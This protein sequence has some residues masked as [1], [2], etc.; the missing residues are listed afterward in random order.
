[1]DRLGY[2]VLNTWMLRLCVCV[3]PL[4]DKSQVMAGVRV[5]PGRVSR[6]EPTRSDGFLQEEM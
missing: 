6:L 3:A 2:R 4:K 1:M 5:S